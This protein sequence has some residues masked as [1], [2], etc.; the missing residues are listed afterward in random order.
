[1]NQS[2][3]VT[4]A[5]LAIGQTL[6]VGCT[7]VKG[8][9]VK[10]DIAEVLE[11]PSRNTALNLLN[12]DDKRFDASKIKA[13]HAFNLSATP[14]QM[15]KYFGVSAKDVEALEEGKTMELNILNPELEGKRLRLQI[16]ESFIGTDYQ[17]KNQEKTAKQ[18]KNSKTGV[19]SFFTIGGKPIFSNVSA[20]N[21]TVSHRIMH[22]DA[23]LSWSDVSVSEATQAKTE[24]LNDQGE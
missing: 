20:T 10:L 8:G 23:L 22:A 24:A 11:N 7:K 17:M 1:M 9:K 4:L 6:L 5:T 13:R 16:T 2:K 12:A 21:G 18:S 3:I 15:E 14:A 19:I